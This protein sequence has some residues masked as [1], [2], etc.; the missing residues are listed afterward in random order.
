MN[1]IEFYLRFASCLFILMMCW[2]VAVPLTILN[3]VKIDDFSNVWLNVGVFALVI[4]PP[5]IAF[6]I[7]RPVLKYLDKK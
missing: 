3:A 2:G 5:I 7:I 6:F 4:L 1:I